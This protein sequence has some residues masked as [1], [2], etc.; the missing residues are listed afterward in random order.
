MLAFLF[1]KCY[2]V[3]VYTYYT[4]LFRSAFDTIAALHLRRDLLSI[5]LIE[6]LHLNINSDD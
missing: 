4:H 3:R 2:L 1:S 6:E 5:G